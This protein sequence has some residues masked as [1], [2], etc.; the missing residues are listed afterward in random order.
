MTLFGT[1]LSPW[2]MVLTTLY[3]ADVVAILL[4]VAFARFRRMEIA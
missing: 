1:P 2:H 4:L 3:A